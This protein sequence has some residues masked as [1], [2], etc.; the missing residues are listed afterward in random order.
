[1]QG[2]E[3]PAN[4]LIRYYI[5]EAQTQTLDPKGKSWLHWATCKMRIQLAPPHDF[6]NQG[7]LDKILKICGF[8]LS[9]MMTMTCLWFIFTKTDCSK[10]ALI[11]TD[12]NCLHCGRIHNLLFQMKFWKWPHLIYH[13]SYTVKLFI[14]WYYYVHRQII[15][16]EFAVSPCRIKNTQTFWCVMGSL[17]VFQKMPWRFVSSL[18]SIDHKK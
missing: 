11:P 8:H 5:I 17:L 9:N 7:L 6:D 15:L 13:A 1:M 14:Y 4:C 18:V 10:G 12:S 2:S 16:W 3:S